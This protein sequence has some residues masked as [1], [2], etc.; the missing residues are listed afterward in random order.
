MCASSS[1]LVAEC[2][3]LKWL[4]QYISHS[5]CA[6]ATDTALSIEMWG[7]HSLHLKSGGVCNCCDRQNVVEV[8]LSE[9][10]VHKRQYGFYQSFSLSLPLSP[11]LFPSPFLKSLL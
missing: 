7:L 2:I 4:H 3:F 1:P 11:S 10:W 9:L 5:I 6:I 8:T